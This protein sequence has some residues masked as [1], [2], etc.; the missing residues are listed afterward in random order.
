MT[1]ILNRDTVGILGGM[2]PLAS[3][4]FLKTIY[5]LSLGH[6]EQDSPVVLMYSDPGFPDRTDEFLRG[7]FEELLQRLIASLNSLLKMGATSIVICC[8]TIHH[9]LPKLPPAVRKRI[10]S[11]LDVIL[12]D[13]AQ[14]RQRHLMICSNGTRRLGLFQ[15][16]DQWRAVKSRILLPDETDQNMIHHELIYK[17]KKNEHLDNFLPLLDYLLRKYGADSFIGG[18]TE[19]HVVTKHVGLLGKAS[20]YP[21]VDPL[22]IIA[23]RLAEKTNEA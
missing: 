18:C 5:E 21:C 10:I 13:V 20:A 3:A 14:S 19:F 1:Q 6:R 4:E 11:L 12:A 8:V 7:S 23:R 16:H 9:L 15:S 17:V 22:M 2:G